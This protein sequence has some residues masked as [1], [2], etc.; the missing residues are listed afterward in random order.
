MATDPLWYKDAVV[1]ELRVRSFLDSNA[2]G[3]GDLP[4]L[5]A[6]LDYLA[7][8]GVDALWLLPFYPSPLRDD[9]Y[10][11]AS[12]VDVHPDCGTLADFREF[13]RQAHRRDLKVI[14]EL[15]LNHTSDQHPWFQRAR[16]AAP[17]TKA[18][19]FYLWSDDPRRFQEA[20]IIFK[21]FESSNWAWDPVAKAYYW[22]RFYAHQPD[23][24]FDN[25]AVRKEMLRIVD[26]WLKMGVDGLRLDAVPYLFERD[27][28]S[29][30][31]LPETHGFLRELRAHVDKHYKDR[32][33]LAEANQWPEDAA[34]YFGAGD[35]CHMAFHFPI[36]PR[37]Y[38]ALRM[39]NSFPILD[40]LQQ[41][42]SIPDTC[43]WAIFLRNHDELTLEMVTDEER[44][45]LVKA[46]ARER[47]ARINLG[48]RRRLAPLLNNNR[49]R[50]EL[51]TALLLSLPGTPVIYYG[52]EI[53]MGDNVYLGDRDGVRTPMQWTPDR[54][55]GF[56]TVNPQK[57]ILPVITD[58]EYHYQ[59]VNV[60]T[61]HTNPSSLVWW[62]RRTIALR[63]QHPAFGRGTFEPLRPAN[64]R[65]LAYVRK[66]GS[67]ALLVVA[68]L[69]RFPQH[70]SLDLA[71]YAGRGVRELFGRVKFPRI[72]QAPYVLTLGPHGFFWFELAE[73]HPAA[74]LTTAPRLPLVHVEGDAR[75]LA[76]MLTDGDKGELGAAMLAYI[77]HCRWFRGKA[78]QPLDAEVVAAQP[79]ARNDAT[80]VLAFVRVAYAEGDPEIYLLPLALVSDAFG[81]PS[82]VCEL[83]WADG[84]QEPARFV[85]EAS[86]APAL[87]QALLELVASRNK[88]MA[89]VVSLVAQLEKGGRKLLPPSDAT[90]PRRL[91]GEQTNT[92]WTFGDKVVAK[93]VRKIEDGISPE[94]ELGKHL[95]GEVHFAHVP[96]LI[97][98]IEVIAPQT[99]PATILVVQE[100]IANHGDAWR[101]VL[102]DLSRYFE[103]VRALPP[104]PA[105]TAPGG[106]A[107]DVAIA[108]AL[109]AQ[110]VI[111]AGRVGPLA[112]LMELLGRR[113]GE[114]H[115][116]LASAPADSMMAPEPFTPFFQRALYQ[117]L[118]NL[119]VR[120]LGALESH[121]DDFV[122]ATRGSVLRLVASRDRILERFRMLVGGPLGGQR[123]R[124]HGDLHL[125]QILWT[126]DDVVFID[127]EGEP[128]RTM[129]DRKTKRSPLIDVAGMLR[130]F[131]YAVEKAVTGQL[132]GSALRPADEKTLRPWARRWL[133]AA[134][135]TFLRAY[136]GQAGTTGLLPADLQQL[137]SLLRIYILEKALY[138]VGYE[139]NHRPDW[140]EV[141]L[142]GVLALL[143]EPRETSV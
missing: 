49:R 58:P 43:Q 76:R 87:G 28:T 127:F 97:G 83:A 48:I 108:L 70:V 109:D 78:R 27:G 112:H 84:R 75:S 90:V 86:D 29:C 47:R 25:P 104:E 69:S 60:E 114:L 17:G 34:A 85:A 103:T 21:D 77:R 36:M 45:Y 20:R 121:V 137:S 65:V 14:T 2:D 93:L 64:H 51:M 101:L 61:Q 6:R 135:A 118:R 26:F 71:A 62:M 133:T 134:S 115:Q 138:E 143:E 120:V 54:N 23:L 22:H 19:D 110:A 9:G 102:D 30:E 18:R 7:D 32:M 50:L 129:G 139:A 89:N 59:A 8:L 124:C 57:L 44:D 141:P 96:H 131:D 125:G 100:Q 13:L 107:V 38:M 11:I 68:N 42:P 130:S 3:I 140:I 67:S 72:T 74:D 10:D 73:D 66:L 53:G 92:T 63:K 56:S 105:P 126:G 33:L 128:A 136:V 88:L 91:K 142:R 94:V 82:L 116:A 39:E 79:I 132:Q 4:G 98:H 24:N 80:F 81:P 35:E 119:V 15:V 106:G 123:I 41:T 12:Y 122:P 37:L 117:S 31:N 40:I 5:T 55:A 46:Y 111:D 52:D 1:Y 95:S 16:R 113:L 99:E